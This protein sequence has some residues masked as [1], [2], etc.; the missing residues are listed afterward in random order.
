VAG[1][2]LA[3]DDALTAIARQNIVNA[4]QL[5][6]LL[7]RKSSFGQT[8]ENSTFE[9]DASGALNSG[10]LRVRAAFSERAQPS[11]VT[12]R[13]NVSTSTA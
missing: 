12:M 13:H 2:A 11:A 5:V 9:I 7:D 8:A 3:G 10:R 6:D 4:S 1:L